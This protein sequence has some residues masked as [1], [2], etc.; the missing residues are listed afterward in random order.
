MLGRPVCFIFGHRIDRTRVWHDGLDHRT[1]CRRCAALM[2][3]HKQ[4]W[5]PFVMNQ[6][7][8]TRRKPHPHFDR[9]GTR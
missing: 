3:K 6:D 7:V 2:L 5:R 9:V 1:T 4:G 8:D